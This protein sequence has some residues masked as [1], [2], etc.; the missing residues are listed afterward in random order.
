[1]KTYIY[2]GGGDGIP[3]LPHQITDQQ[4]AAEGL[5]E[6]LNSAIDSG[7]YIEQADE[8]PAKKKEK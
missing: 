4:A 5:T 8:K 1:M 3:G 2:V 6:L 7:A